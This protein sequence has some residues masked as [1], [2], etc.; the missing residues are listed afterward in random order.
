MKRLL[1]LLLLCVCLLPF[2]SCAL[3][4]DLSDLEFEDDYN[5]LTYNGSNYYRTDARFVLYIES[6][7]EIVELGHRVNWPVFPTFYYLAFEK[8]SPLFISGD[9]GHTGPS[10]YLYVRSDFDLENATYLLEGTDLN[11]LEGTN[12]E[13]HLS[14]IMTEIQP[15]YI[16][17]NYDP[18][19]DRDIYFTL[20][21]EPRLRARFMGPYQYEENWYVS[22]Y[23]DK[24]YPS[25]DYLLSDEFVAQLKASGI[26]KE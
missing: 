9:H 7:D 17:A 26:I 3:F 18:V 25:K 6:E 22:S 10:F 21:D 11:T 2:T 8:D 23:G 4:S 19:Y 14:D 15:E 20:K 1:A 24:D 16:P 12:I 13:V 5:L